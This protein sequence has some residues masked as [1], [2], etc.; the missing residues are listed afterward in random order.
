MKKLLKA[1]FLPVD[2]EQLLY[3]QYQNCRQGT[4]FVSEYTDEFYSLNA[5]N[6]LNDTDNQA[7]ARYIGRLKLVIHDKLVLPQIWTLSEAVNF[8]LKIEGQLNRPLF[9]TSAPRRS[10]QEPSQVNRRTSTDTTW[11]NNNTNSIPAQQSSQFQQ[12]KG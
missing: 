11:D 4:R 1:R 12:K 2:N 6:N 10:S 9:R 7:L 5:R 8:A 3:Q